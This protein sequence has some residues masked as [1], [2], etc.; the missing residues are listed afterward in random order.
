[1]HTVVFLLYVFHSLYKCLNYCT[2]IA[3]NVFHVWLYSATIAFTSVLSERLG[4]WDVLD[5]TN[6]SQHNVDC[7]VSL[8]PSTNDSEMDS[9]RDLYPGKEVKADDF[10]NEEII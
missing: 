4:N 2:V 7:V 3:Y 8:F 5:S 1:M 9:P 10:L 6:D